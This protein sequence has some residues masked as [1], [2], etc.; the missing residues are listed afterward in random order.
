MVD[1]SSK[2]PIYLSHNFHSAVFKNN[3]PN[4][5][6]EDRALIKTLDIL[7]EGF[8]IMVKISSDVVRGR[9]VLTGNAREILRRLNRDIY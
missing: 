2:L 7:F 9:D 8:S 5:L 6:K 3:L 4:T 1:F